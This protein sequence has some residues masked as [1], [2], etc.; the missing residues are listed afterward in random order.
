[1]SAP[2]AVTLAL[3]EMVDGEFSFR[4]LPYVMPE[5]TEIGPPVL[6]VNG[7]VMLPNA[8]EGIM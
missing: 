2:L 7:P 1:M 8:A 3:M 6:I 4:L 5:L